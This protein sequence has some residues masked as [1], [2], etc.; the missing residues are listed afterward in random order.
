MPQIPALR[1]FAA[2]G[3]PIWGTCAGLIFLAD[4]AVGARVRACRGAWSVDRQALKRVRHAGQ[5]D[6]GQALIG[7][8]DI[9]VSRN[10]FGSQIDSFEMHLPAPASFPA[11]SGCEI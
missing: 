1:E 3:R 11:A 6:G 2:S 8:L 5:K 4:R 10:F 7:G 9:T